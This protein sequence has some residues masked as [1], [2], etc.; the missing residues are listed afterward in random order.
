FLLADKGYDVWL[1]NIRGNTYSRKHVNYSP[2]EQKYWNFSFHEMG[3]SDIPACIDFILKLTN[4]DK[5]TYIGHSM[6][7]TMFYVMVSMRP[8]YNEKILVQLSLAP[9]AYLS[10]ATSLVTLVAPFEIEIGVSIFRVVFNAK[11]KIENK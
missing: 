7:T 2:N 1:G 8:E 10:H 3:T 11:F 6:G 4:Q 9:I 5:V